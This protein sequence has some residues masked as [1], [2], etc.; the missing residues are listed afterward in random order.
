MRIAIAGAS[1]FVGTE[2]VRQLREAGDDIL[3]LVRREPI[4][5]DELG[6]D[7]AAGRLDPASLRGVDAV[8]NL[9]GE[10]VGHIP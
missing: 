4:A 5:P 1:G 9:A 2:L 6:W 3:R 7:P 10:S 8:V